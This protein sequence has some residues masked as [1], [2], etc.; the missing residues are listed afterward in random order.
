MSGERE[1]VKAIRTIVGGTGYNTCVAR[2]RSVN[3]ATCVVERI[4]DGK[5]VDDVRLNA[6]V[7]A[8]D[9]LVIVPSAGSYVLITTVD[10][11]KWFVAQFSC[12]E[13]ITLNVTDTVEVN[14][15]GENLKSILSDFID[16][17][18][19]IIVVQGTSPNVPALNL[20]KQRL[21]KILK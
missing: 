2:V 3:G 6:T 14:A 21:N 4:L 19:K 10:G 7:A 5:T 20:I 17:V 9:G 15:G 8:G 13:R 1:C 16:E 12:V 18:A 11:D